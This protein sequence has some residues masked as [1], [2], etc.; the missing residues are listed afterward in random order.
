M[1]EENTEYQ[2][3]SSFRSIYSILC[4]PHPGRVVLWYE[5]TL[6]GGA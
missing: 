2:L 3:A 5:T 6:A 4:L 1:S